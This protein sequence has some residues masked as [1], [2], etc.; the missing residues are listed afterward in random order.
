MTDLHSALRAEIALRHR[1]DDLLPFGAVGHAI[2]LELALCRIEGRRACMKD[3]CIAAFGR[4]HTT[5]IAYVRLLTQAGLVCRS[6]CRGDRRLGVLHITDEGFALVA[7]VL[8]PEAMARA[9]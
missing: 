5:A 3:A 6:D 8:A 9:A 7:A 4:P 1:A 2:M